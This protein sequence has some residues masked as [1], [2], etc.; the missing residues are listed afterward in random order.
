MKILPDP[1]RYAPT[2]PNSL[3]AVAL[4]QGSAS[5]HLTPEKLLVAAMTQALQAGDDAPIDQALAQAPSFAVRRA[6]GRAL[7]E[8]L[9]APDDSALQWR[10]FSIPFLIVTGGLADATI[11]GALPDAAALTA[12]FE[13]HGALGAQ[14]NFALG[15]ALI[16]VE[17][18]AALKPTV[19]WRLSHNEGS[20]E[21]APLDL[22]PAP[23]HL[24]SAA[25]QVHLRFLNGVSV[26]ASDA[27]AFTETA[28]N[29][30]AWGM[31]V[32]RELAAQLGQPGLSFLPIPRPP[33][34]PRQAIEAGVFSYGE[35]GLQLFLSDALRKF[36]A[37]VG[38][39]SATVAS[40]A[41]GSVR[42]ALTSPFDASLSTEY[43]WKLQPGDDIAA[44]AGSIF[45]LLEEC[46]VTDV[47]VAEGV[48]AASH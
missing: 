19:L 4:E 39:A 9:R 47:Q 2:S 45:S 38:E 1:R 18:M 21:S 3:L 42:V 7:D 10:F 17:G 32:T 26:T 35:L 27:P 30:A 24:T 40:R 13:K 33:M 15:N 34:A 48:Q 16:S 36:R 37:R 20:S 12:L 25:E 29:I 28:G 43:V 22:A 8:A 5:Q 6:L 41:D 14:K 11:A 31:P 23:I 46:R 44:V